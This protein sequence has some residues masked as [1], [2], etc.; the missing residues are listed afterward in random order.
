[1]AALEKPHCGAS[2]VPFMKRT[3]GVDVTAC[4]ILSRASWVMNRRATARER[5]VNVGVTRRG[6][7]C[8][9]PSAPRC[10]KDSEY[11]IQMRGMLTETWL[12]RRW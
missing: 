10:R 4:W 5:G 3:T 11:N 9:T 12:E 2:G 8:K 1:M 7:S 6:V